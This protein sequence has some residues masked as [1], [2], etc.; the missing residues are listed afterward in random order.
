MQVDA[1]GL[2]VT[3]LQVRQQAIFVQGGKVE[4]RVLLTFYVGNHGPFEKQ[5]TIPEYSVEA[6]RQ[7]IASTVAGLRD[8]MQSV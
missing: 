2:A 8:L 7:Y 3:G 4:Q 5:F 6:A 1:N